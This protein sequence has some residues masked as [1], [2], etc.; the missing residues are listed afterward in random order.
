[1]QQLWSA[2]AVYRRNNRKTG[3][4]NDN[5]HNNINYVIDEYQT[6][7][8]KANRMMW[9][10]PVLLTTKKQFWGL[11]P[12]NLSFPLTSSAYVQSSFGWVVATFH[13]YCYGC[14]GAYQ[15]GH[16]SSAVY[17]KNITLLS[18][19]ERLILQNNMLRNIVS[20]VIILCLYGPEEMYGMCGKRCVE[21]W[22]IEVSLYLL[23]STVI[24]LL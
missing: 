16:I 19:S 21:E 9:E 5:K 2:E 6:N 11:P 18:L 1:M 8:G 4:I 13:K 14:H 24:L 17:S 10:I 22:W 3:I 20:N 15:Y 23:V 7:H 12:Y